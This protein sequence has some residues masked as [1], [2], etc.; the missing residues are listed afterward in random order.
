MIKVNQY[1]SGVKFFQKI[2]WKVEANLHQ[3]SLLSLC[4]HL[5]SLFWLHHKFCFFNLNFDQ[6]IV[7][8]LQHQITQNFNSNTHQTGTNY[9]CI[10][11]NHFKVVIYLD[12]DHIPCRTPK[13][14]INCSYDSKLA[15]FE[16]ENWMKPKGQYNTTKKHPIVNN[17]N[18]YYHFILLWL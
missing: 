13:D 5:V 6:K 14:A 8:S 1:L 9:L 16:I 7:F 3:Y 15:K 12:I 10:H 18:I 2:K 4:C 11:D 17:N